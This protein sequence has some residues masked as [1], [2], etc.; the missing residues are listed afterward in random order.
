MNTQ[1][2][3]ASSQAVIVVTQLM[4]KAKTVSYKVRQLK[5]LE[6]RDQCIFTVGET[7]KEASLGRSRK[8]GT[9]YSHTAY[10]KTCGERK[11]EIQVKRG[12]VQVVLM[13]VTGIG[14][15]IQFL[16]PILGQE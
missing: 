16:C 3:Q 8:P 10:L 9:H 5:Q 1:Q 14:T 6:R 15:T 4:E 12:T 11:S 13:A 2:I 7:V